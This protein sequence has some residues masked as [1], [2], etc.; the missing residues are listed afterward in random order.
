MMGM[1][2]FL[3]S[4][5]FQVLIVNLKLFNDRTSFKNLRF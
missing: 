5:R 3:N 2:K 1:H 4:N